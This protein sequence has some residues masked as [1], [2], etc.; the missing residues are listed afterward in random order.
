MGYRFMG[1][2]YKVKDGV[3]LLHI[4]YKNGLWTYE[5]HIINLY[6]RWGELSMIKEEVGSMF[7]IYTVKPL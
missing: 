2:C 5:A 3:S 4:I 6:E 7:Y 1:P